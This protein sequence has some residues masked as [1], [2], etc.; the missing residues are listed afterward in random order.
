MTIIIF[1]IIL[2][3]LVLSHELGHFSVAKFFGIRVDEFGFGFPPKIFSWKKG[4]TIYYINLLPLGGFVKIFGEDPTSDVLDKDH[5][6]AER[7]LC[8]KPRHIQAAVIFAGV[9]FN[10]ILAW[11][12]M[13]LGFIY[14]LPV[15]EG[16]SKLGPDPASSKLIVTGILKGAPAEEGGLK[17]GVNLVY[18][19]T[20]EDSIQSLNIDS[21]EKFIT[22]HEG[23]E[24][25]VGYKEPANSGVLISV[26]MGP[27]DYGQE[28]KTAVVIPKKG[29]IGDKPG[30]GI[31]MDMIGILKLPFFEAIYAGGVAVYALF[32]STISGLFH[33]IIGFFTGTSTAGSV[34]GPIGLIGI[35][36]DAARFGIAYILALV[37]LISVNLAVLNL[38]PFP[39]LD[40]GRLFFLLIE[41][42]IRKPLNPKVV[43][44]L[45]IAGF[46]FLLV[47]MLVVTYGDILKLI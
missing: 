7:S 46:L 13:S 11:L 33:Y 39:A 34:S 24:I 2:A 43:N 37:A 1:L 40:G 42:I 16:F 36:G 47:L 29:I 32:Q 19:A 18:L 22:S 44:V 25:F 8:H 27:L 20:K 17:P 9:L 41:S 38:V 15:P 14:G 35:V 21:V 26:G 3:V 6:D 10:L 30:I 4:E 28:T 31:S 45:N 5:K 23:Q 12:V